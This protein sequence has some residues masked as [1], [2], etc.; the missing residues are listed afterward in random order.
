MNSL[1][2]KIERATKQAEAEATRPITELDP[3][4]RKGNAGWEAAHNAQRRAKER[5]A[6]VNHLAITQYLTVGNPCG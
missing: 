2:R 1:D 4:W 6:A 5:Q 3:N